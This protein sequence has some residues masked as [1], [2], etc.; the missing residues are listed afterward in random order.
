MKTLIACEVMADEI[1]AVL[2]SDSSVKVV[3][4][5]AALHTDF[6]QLEAKLSTALSEVASKTSQVGV[7][8][9]RGCLPGIELLVRKYDVVQMSAINCIEAL[10]GPHIQEFNNSMLLT[11][12]WVRA[13]PSIMMSMNWDVCDVR[14][15]LGRYKRI[16]ILEPEIRPLSESEILQFFDLTDVF[17]DIEHIGLHYFR[18][19]LQ[20]LLSL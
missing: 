14:M 5:E 11:P 9:G 3:W 6:K 12:G 2:Q 4:L 20:E 19:H 13:W 8:Y 16:V 15:Q 18:E 1:K 7:L 17:I 10:L